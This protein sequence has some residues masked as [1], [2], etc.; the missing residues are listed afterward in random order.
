MHGGYKLAVTH[1][2]N[3]SIIV[4]Y[5]PTAVSAGAKFVVESYHN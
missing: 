1:K 2:Y 3:F 5:R 4:K